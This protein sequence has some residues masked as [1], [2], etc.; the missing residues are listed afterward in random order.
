MPAKR[1]VQS[2][3]QSPANWHNG[4]DKIIGY[5][6]RSTNTPRGHLGSGRRRLEVA[7][8]PACTVR[9]PTAGDARRE[10]GHSGAVGAGQLARNEPES[11]AIPCKSRCPGK[12]VYPG[13]AFLAAAAADS[14]LLGGSAPQ[15]RRAVAAAGISQPTVSWHG[16][17]YKITQQ[18][19]LA[20]N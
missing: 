11:G 7:L 12:T 3:I 18:T 20:S 15:S 6:W 5:S 1:K 16:I 8:V 14:G 2:D 10:G 13:S 4:F 19:L 17:S 9:A